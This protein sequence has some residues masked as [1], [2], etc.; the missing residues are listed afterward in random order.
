MV[1]LPLNDL[2][3]LST[4]DLRSHREELVAAQA[5]VAAPE[6]KAIADYLRGGTLILALMEHTK[7]CSAT[8][9]RRLVG[10]PSE[11]TASGTGAQTLLATSKPMV[12]E[13]PLNSPGI[14]KPLTT[15]LMRSQAPNSLRWMPTWPS[16]WGFA[17]VT[18]ASNDVAYGLI[19]NQKPTAVGQ[20]LFTYCWKRQ[21]CLRPETVTV[22]QSI[23]FAA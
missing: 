20:G 19:D 17:H 22:S 2:G 1:T 18:Q 5:Q 21:S 14:A 8:L 23:W 7:A 4:V 12:L 6:A 16:V 3:V 15:T 10:P 11:A 13:F 9:S